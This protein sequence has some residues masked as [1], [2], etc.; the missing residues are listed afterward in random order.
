MI[1]DEGMDPTEAAEV[2]V[3]E[4]PDVWQEWLPEGYEQRVQ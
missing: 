2:W 3:N 4:N 1:A